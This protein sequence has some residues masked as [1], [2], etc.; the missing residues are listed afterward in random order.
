MHNIAPI[1]N[2]VLCTEKLCKREDHMLSIRT[3]I[4]NTA[5]SKFIN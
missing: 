2:T 5:M 1:V 4:K 3:A